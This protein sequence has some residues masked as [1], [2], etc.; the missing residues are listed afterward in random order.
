M[1]PYTT[2]AS[3]W[4]LLPLLAV[5]ADAQATATLVPAL[6]VWPRFWYYQGPF[7]D[8]AFTVDPK[9]VVQADSTRFTFRGYLAAEDIPV[10]FLRAPEPTYR[11]YNICAELL[12]NEEWAVEQMPRISHQ[13]T[14]QYAIGNSSLS[15]GVTIDGVEYQDL[16]VDTS[17]LLTD[18]EGLWRFYDA[19]SYFV[20]VRPD[21]TGWNSLESLVTVYQENS[22][23]PHYGYQNCEQFLA[24]RTEF[25]GCYFTVGSFTSDDNLF[26][27]ARGTGWINIPTTYSN[28][29][30]LRVSEK[31]RFRQ[32]CCQRLTTGDEVLSKDYP[33]DSVVD[34][35]GSVLQRS[36]GTC[37]SEEYV[38]TPRAS[39]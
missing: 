4:A 10:V 21:S 15:F 26:T 11:N 7:S 34:A 33:V 12:P 39:F 28:L 16:S 30:L 9:T 32:G 36:W 8:L 20:C 23:L 3:C 6:P 22:T 27:A 17:T 31:T 29:L 37:A 19:I 35:D 25:C 13:R 24:A 18:Q 14:L 1:A 38:W 5:T 2:S